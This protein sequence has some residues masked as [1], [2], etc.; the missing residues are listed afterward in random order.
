VVLGLANSIIWNFGPGP[1]SRTST[2][3]FDFSIVQPL[4]RNAG[5][6]RIMERLTVAERGLLANVRT[7][8]QYQQAFYVNVMTGRGQLQSPSRRGGLFGGAGLEGFTGVG[9]GGFGRVGGFGG[10]GG[11]AGGTGGY[12]GLLQSMQEIRNQEDNVERLRSNLFRLEQTLLELRTRSGEPQLVSNILRQDLQVAQSR[13]ALFA[14]ESSLL[15]ARTALQQTLDNFKGTLGLPPQI[16]MEIRDTMLDEFQLIDRATIEQQLELEGMVAAF[17]AVRLRIAQHI[18][19]KAVPDENDPTQTMAVRVLEWYPELDADLQ[20]LK[21]QLSPIRQVRKRLL[22]EHLPRTSR[23]L[24]RLAQSIPR[25]KENLARLKQK[26]EESQQ[27]AC[28]LLPIRRINDEIFQGNRLDE[29]LEELRA[30]L[31]ELNR[32]VED[33]YERSLNDR[34][35]RIDRLLTEGRTYTPERLFTELYE[36]V[37]YPKQELGAA[38]E[39]QAADILVVLPADILAIQLVQARARTETIELAPVDLRAD[40]ALEIARKY[41]R[42]W[43][44]ARASLVD[45]WRLIEFNADQLESTLDVFMNGSVQSVDASPTGQMRLGL[46]FD[47]PITRLAERNTYR[48]ALIDYQQA[49]RSYYNFEDTVARALRT[50]IRTVDTNQLNFELQRLQ[51]LEA[52][53]QID[54]NEDI[55]IE[56]EFSGQATGATAAR[57]AVQALSDLLQAQNDFMSF[58]VNHESLRRS[59]DLDL[60]TIQLDQDGLWID[61]GVIN[62]EYGQM[63]PWLRQGHNFVLPE[64]GHMLEEIPPAAPLPQ[65]MRPPQHSPDFA[66]ALGENVQPASAALPPASSQPASDQPVQYYEPQMLGPADR[67]VGQTPSA[68]SPARLVIPEPD[69]IPTRDLLPAPQYSGEYVPLPAQK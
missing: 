55:R 61:P 24:E 68:V 11:G 2:T 22:E 25:R 4:L 52:A 21:T 28:P 63:D 3:L 35:T 66:A 31:D 17:G 44:N 7:M 51:V 41:R 20:E 50:E 1:D 27:E 47:P 6:D 37:L 18:T 10:G 33:A 9:G 14:A 62:A 39:D 65:G 5:R 15:N 40:Q 69:V 19:I 53:R 26:V 54:R 45:A 12:L 43:M 16:C 49:R 30:Q 57:D 34:E 36:G 48:Q 42:D 46:R 58:W 29:L 38:A 56:S 60:G 13:Q 32:S 59:L 8:E 64:G 67:F 23:D